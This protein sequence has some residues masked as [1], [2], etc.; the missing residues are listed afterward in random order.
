MARDAPWSTDVT[1]PLILDSRV[2]GTLEFLR[3]ALGVDWASP[4]RKRAPASERYV[5]YCRTAHRW[6]RDLDLEPGIVG[7][8]R[9]E[10][11]LFEPNDFD[12]D[13]YTE[14]RQLAVA[15]LRDV[16]NGAAGA[17]TLAAAEEMNP[18]LR[19]SLG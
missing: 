11:I 14:M 13:A 19:E 16:H 6:A 15:I 5:H 8:E 3:R 1:K 17:H 9:I 7:A 4:L 12:F 2:E 18:D 10:L